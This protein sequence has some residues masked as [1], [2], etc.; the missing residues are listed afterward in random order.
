MTGERIDERSAFE[1]AL[2]ETPTDEWT[3]VL[4]MYGYRVTPIPKPKREITIADLP[5]LDGGQW[6]YSNSFDYLTMDFNADNLTWRNGDASQVHAD[7]K[8]LA[9]QMIESGEFGDEVR[10]ALEDTRT[11]GN[12]R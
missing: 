7:L 6:K 9:R 11:E 1:K 12:L 8:D 4:E 5:T 2:L 3:G 10:V